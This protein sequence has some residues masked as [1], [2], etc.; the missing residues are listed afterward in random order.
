MKKISLLFSLFFS[1]LLLAG[2]FET[3]D[4]IT[5][6]ADGSGTVLYTNDMSMLLSLAKSMG[7]AEAMKEAGDK[8][9]DTT[10]SLSKLADSILS[11]SP[12]Q[13]ELV[14]QGKLKAVVDLD[15]EK[16]VTRLEIPFK[17]IGQ[18]ASIKEVTA[19]VTQFFL[20]RSMGGDAA[21]MDITEKMPSSDPLDEYFTTEYTK[22][23]IEKKLNKEKY[24]LVDSS[25][26]MKGVREMSDNGMPLSNTIII[27]LPKPAKLVEGKNAKLSEDKKKVTITSSSEEFFESPSALEFRIVF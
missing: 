16:M 2:C 24:A 19:K 12:E 14:R 6:N 9:T 25:E 3:T 26:T 22:S 17:N 21:G 7:G 23:G 10:V 27:N 11:L 18:V 4:E 1:V 13:R 8:P 20:G 15:D 5:L